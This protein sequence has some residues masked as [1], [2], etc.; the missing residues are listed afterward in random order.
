MEEKKSSFRNQCYLHDALSKDIGNDIFSS[1]S[2]IKIILENESLLFHIS[3]VKKKS[4]E[5]KWRIC[6]RKEQKLRV[7]IDFLVKTADVAE[8]Y[9]IHF[10]YK[11]IGIQTAIYKNMLLIYI[12]I[13]SSKTI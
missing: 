13:Y 9:T 12:H 11:Y 5:S 8:V 3:Y 10:L 2:S 7:I 1:C 4:S 6:E